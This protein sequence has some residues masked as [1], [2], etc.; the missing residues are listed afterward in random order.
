VPEKPDRQT[1]RRTRR[2]D[3]DIKN[4]GSAQEEALEEPVMVVMA[5]A[6]RLGGRVRRAPLDRSRKV[7]RAEDQGT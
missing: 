3:Q 1:D 4:G 7:P 5:E 2:R 6:H